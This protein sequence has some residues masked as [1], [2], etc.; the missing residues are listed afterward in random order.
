M[1]DV[2]NQPLAAPQR[3]TPQAMTLISLDFSLDGSSSEIP[4]T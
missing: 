1:V 4:S 3:P 2:W